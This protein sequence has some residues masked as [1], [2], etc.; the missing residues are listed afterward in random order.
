[1]SGSYGNLLQKYNTLQ[2]QIDEGI[3]AFVPING[4]STI[5]GI[6]TFTL[7]P[8]CDEVATQTT[9]LTTKA[10]VDNVVGTNSGSGLL[11]YLN[12]G[13]SS[14][15]STFKQ[16]A[17]QYTVL[18]LTSTTTTSLGTNLV[19]SFITDTGIPNIYGSSLSA[20]IFNLNLYAYVS[21]NTGILNGFF[22][23]NKYDTLTSTTTLISTSGNSS[24]INGTNASAPDLYHMSAS[25]PTT[26]FLS[27]DRLLLLVYT[28][29]TGMGG[30]QTITT[31]YQG[32]YYSYLLTP[33]S[34]GAPLVSSNNNWTGTNSFLNSVS[35]YQPTVSTSPLTMPAGSSIL[36]GAGTLSIGNS[37]NN[38]VIGNGLRVP[39]YIDSVELTTGLFL[40]YNHSAGFVNSLLPIIADGLT[41][42]SAVYS[43][44]LHPKTSTTG[45]LN[46][47]TSLTTGALNIATTAMTGIITIG[48][49]ANLVASQLLNGPWGITSV[50][51]TSLFAGV[52][53]SA[54]S[55]FT[56]T[57]GTITLGNAAVLNCNVSGTSATKIG[58][59]GSLQLG[60]ATSAVTTSNSVQ[61]ITAS[62]NVSLYTSTTG[63]VTLGAIG[64]I[65][66]GSVSQTGS[67]T[68]YSKALGIL[69]NSPLNVNYGVPTL[70]TTN[71][72]G[73][74]Y[75]A[76]SQQ[77]TSNQTAIGTYTVY[78][79]V[80]L[81]RLTAG[82]Y[83]FCCNGSVVIF[84]G[85]GTVGS[86]TMDI[87]FNTT[88]TSVGST[89]FK[90][91]L[92]P[93]STIAGVSQY[94]IT[95]FTS[96]QVNTVSVAN[97]LKYFAFSISFAISATYTTGN[98]KALIDSYSITRIA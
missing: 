54:I 49:T 83:L 96:S 8:H 11:F 21:A 32:S 3:G 57:T 48:N 41:T 81:P 9:D 22:T 72:I 80:S 25:F 51:T 12:F 28:T 88:N 92:T 24:D 64:D 86:L 19:S 94:H 50:R 58:N 16:L 20:G 37:T 39:K 42:N 69:L 71:Q 95:P 75:S 29:G 13:I 84:N 91:L 10:Y 53:S 56:A 67:T 35:L 93:P 38:I 33:I 63:S 14:G 85:T 97:D 77:T 15:I 46:I 90:S 6:K 59:S 74:T 60:T 52:A 17:N 79:S 89:S 44:Y 2:S 4:D 1:M 82:I 55:L 7:A 98:V 40:G 78:S 87:I 61:Q 68:L 43:D 27:T 30:G 47:G 66:I 5:N 45:T 18:S 76:N 73:Y 65:T 36:M 62:N 70:T 31:L 34:S 23:L 26:A